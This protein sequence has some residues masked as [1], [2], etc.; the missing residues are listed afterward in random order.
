[1]KP[2]VFVM[3]WMMALANFSYADDKADNEAMLKA[4]KMLD[5]YGD[6]W[7]TADAASRASKLR[8]IWVEGGIHQSPFGISEGVD[9]I[10]GEI[11]GFVE[12]LPGVK[13][14]FSDIKITGNNLVV[15]FLVTNDKNETVFKG[16]D[17]MEF[18]EAGKLIKVIGFL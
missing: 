8:T 17:Y 7:V 11:A 4:E 1:M 13:I 12:S 6:S 15:Q 18:T 5:A 2:I 10:D 3:V 14:E 16:V 9:A